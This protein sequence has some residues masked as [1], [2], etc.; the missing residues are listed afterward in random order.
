MRASAAHRDLFKADPEKFA[1]QFAGSCAM[2]LT[3]GLKIEADPNNWTI[4]N[5]KLYVFAGSAGPAKL[6]QDPGAAIAQAKANWSTLKD[7]AYQ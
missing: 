6:Q 5:G 1:P 4:S 7:A 3:R 2:S